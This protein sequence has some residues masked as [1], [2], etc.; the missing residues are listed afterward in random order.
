MS[1]PGLVLPST[2]KLPSAF[3]INSEAP[4]A[5][6]LAPPVD[7]EAKGEEE[8]HQSRPAKDPPNPT[9]PMREKSTWGRE[10]GAVVAVARGSEIRRRAA[11]RR[12]RREGML[13]RAP[14]VEGLCR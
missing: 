9:C 6:N 4:S 3:C 12:E 1:P 7:V 5:E 13:A 10:V 8:V 14:R 11:R 2:V